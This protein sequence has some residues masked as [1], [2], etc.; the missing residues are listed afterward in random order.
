MEPCGGLHVLV[1][2]RS[3]EKEKKRADPRAGDAPSEEREAEDEELDDDDDASAHRCGTRAADQ[4]ANFGGTNPQDSDDSEQIVDFPVSR[5][6]ACVPVAQRSNVTSTSTHV[7]SQHKRMLFNDDK[8]LVDIPSIDTTVRAPRRPLPCCA[9]KSR[10]T[11]TSHDG[12][13]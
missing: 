1:T 11:S 8:D 6:I 2:E 3:T 13:S 7:F 4:R 9:K 10:R 12:S 5:V